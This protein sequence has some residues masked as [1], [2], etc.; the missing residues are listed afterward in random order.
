LYV[1]IEDQRV[2][3]ST[4]VADGQTQNQFATARLV[5]QV[6][7]H[8]GSQDVQFCGEQCPF[9]AEQQTVVLADERFTLRVNDEA[10]WEATLARLFRAGYRRCDVVSAAG[11]YAVLT[12]GQRIHA[13]RHEKDGGLIRLVSKS[14]ATIE[15]PADK[16]SGFEQ[17]EYVAHKEIAK[18][19]KRAF[20]PRAGL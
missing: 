12:N 11:E 13:D 6:A 16:V 14:G 4:P 20:I 5:E 19:M 3:V 17:E 18:S 7:T 1:R 15:F 2:V 8:A 9:D 10:G